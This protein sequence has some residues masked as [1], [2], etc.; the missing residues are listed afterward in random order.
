[1]FLAV[2]GCQHKLFVQIK[3]YRV[4]WKHSSNASSGAYTCGDKASRGE[5][6]LEL[7]VPIKSCSLLIT[8]L[9]QER[10]FFLALC[11]LQL[12]NSWQFVQFQPG[13]TTADFAWE[14]LVR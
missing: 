11:T 2:F 6:Q 7:L 13:W 10:Q 12:F 1:M 8:H 5:I 4:R 14:K 9:A 3:T